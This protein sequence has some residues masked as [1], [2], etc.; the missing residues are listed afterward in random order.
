M[1]GGQ[2][3][4]EP[5]LLC[6]SWDQKAP[7]LL[8]QVCSSQGSRGGEDSSVPPHT[9]GR[10]PTRDEAAPRPAALHGTVGLGQRYRTPDPPAG[11]GKNPRG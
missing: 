3:G 8:S 2:Q 7:T 5:P 11:T 4:P 9:E 6:R 10:D 1:A